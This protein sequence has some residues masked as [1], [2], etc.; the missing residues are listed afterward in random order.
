MLAAA[1]KKAALTV[2]KKD[3][4]AKCA[5]PALSSPS[6]LPHPHPYAKPQPSD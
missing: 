4:L 2:Q 5:P 1:D 6:A 3:F